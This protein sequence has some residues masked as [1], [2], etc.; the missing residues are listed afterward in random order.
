[1]KLIYSDSGKD[2]YQF[3]SAQKSLSLYKA[4]FKDIYN[5]LLAGKKESTSIWAEKWNETTHVGVD[6]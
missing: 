3:Q 5:T 1:M 4:S 2:E 6:E